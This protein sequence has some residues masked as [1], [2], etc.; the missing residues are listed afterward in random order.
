[1]PCPPPGD[2]PPRDGTQISCFAADSLPPSH[3]GKRK[4]ICHLFLKVHVKTGRAPGSRRGSALS[5]W[6]SRVCA[7]HCTVICCFP[8]VRKDLA[9]HHTG[10]GGLRMLRASLSL[11]PRSLLWAFPLVSLPLTCQN[12]TLPEFSGGGSAWKL[13]PWTG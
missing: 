1:M 2:S 8:P 4:D 9:R 5:S 10:L 6:F 12:L 3:L 11:L 7:V 13:P